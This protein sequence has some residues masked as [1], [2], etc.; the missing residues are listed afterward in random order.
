MPSKLYQ[1]DSIEVLKGLDPVR[2]RPGMYTDTSRPNHLAQEVI[3]NSVDEALEGAATEIRVT[4]RKDGAMSVSDDGRGMPVDV[5]KGE[6]LPGVEVILT[7]LHSGAKFNSENYKF[8]GGLHGVGVSVVNALSSELTLTIWREGQIWEQTYHHG[9]PE[10][11]LKAIGTTEQ[12]GTRCRF[13][14]SE[15]TFSNIEFSY[16][17]LAILTRLM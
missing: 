5:H 10:A 16:D 2:K 9:E 12:T 4:L 1:A 13:K 8:S 17:V 11:P 14:P 6:K 7:Q 15:E 3:D